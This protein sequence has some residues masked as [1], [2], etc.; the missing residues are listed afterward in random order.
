M[1]CKYP[2]DVAPTVSLFKLLKRFFTVTILV[3]Q[4]DKPEEKS[5]MERAVIT[6]TSVSFSTSE[7]QSISLET[8]PTE[9]RV[10]ENGETVHVVV[11]TSASQ[12]EELPRDARSRFRR[13]FK[14]KRL[15]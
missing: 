10:D 12:P 3:E 7:S 1:T 2:F 13:F 5:V 8:N 15:Y 9:S 14:Q 11:A 4:E 6:G